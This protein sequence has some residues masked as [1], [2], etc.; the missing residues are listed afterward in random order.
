MDVLYVFVHVAV[1]SEFYDL[2]HFIFDV[3]AT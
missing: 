1:S 3:L 2:K